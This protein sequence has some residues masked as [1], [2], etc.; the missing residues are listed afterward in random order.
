MLTAIR[1]HLVYP[2]GDPFAGDPDIAIVEH[3]DGLLIVNDGIIEAVGDHA[4]LAPTLPARVGVTHYPNA[5]IVP[6]FVDCHVHYVQT[7]IVGA[8]GAQLTEWLERY[9]F[10]AERGFADAGHGAATAKVFCDELLRNGTTSALVFASVHP[11]S[12]DALFAEA[13]GRG[14]ALIAGKVLMDRNA[15][16]DLLDTPQRGY[17]ESKAL[18]AR[19]HGR[20]RL[21]YAITPRF[22]P[23]SSPEQLE[24]ASALRREHPDVHIHT[25]LAE[26]TTEVEWVKRLFPERRSY[27]DVYAHHG[28]VG[29]RAM[30][31]HAIHLDEEDYCRCHETGAALA[32]C[33]TS[34]LFLG[35]GLFRMDRAKDA[36]RPVQVGL[37]TDIGAG[38]SFSLLATAGEAYK[39][40]QLGGASL[41]PAQALYLATLGGARALGLDDRLGTFASGLAADVVVLDPSATKLLAYRNARSQAALETLF[42][43][44]TLGDDR[45]VRATYAAGR[46]A[47]DRDACK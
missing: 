7:G 3:A 37:G 5:L 31:A 4:T 6:G 20:G 15:P 45:V 10:P 11:P 47:H 25:H 17:D 27:L 40:A 13:E 44:M 38:T 34:N 16:A 8:Y 1:G 26:N 23:T 32:H 41:H 14:L 21:R 30:F 29:R 22:A 19:W 39:V 46:L 42:V 9:A 12:V 24:L 2:V 43:L 28:L 18:I 36:R 35:S 33:P